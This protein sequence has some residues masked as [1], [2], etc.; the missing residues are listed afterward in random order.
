M[1]TGPMMRIVCGL[2]LSIAAGLGGLF[3]PPAVAAPDAVADFYRGPFFAPPGVPP[4]RIQALRDA[5]EQKP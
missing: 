5:F 3:P 1:R 4:E 2:T